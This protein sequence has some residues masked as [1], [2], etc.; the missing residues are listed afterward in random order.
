MGLRAD[1]VLDWLGTAYGHD[2]VFHVFIRDGS[3]IAIVYN[4][5]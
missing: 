3:Y 1:T 4:D 5:I 2:A